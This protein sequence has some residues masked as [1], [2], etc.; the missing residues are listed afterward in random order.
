MKKKSKNYCGRKMIKNKRK[1]KKRN[2][3]IIIDDKKKANIQKN[4]NWK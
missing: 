3:R 4:K 1:K 2:R